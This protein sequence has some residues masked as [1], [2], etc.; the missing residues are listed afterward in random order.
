MK[1]I[2]ALIICVFSVFSL[3]AC[4]ETVELRCD[5]EGC[6]NT[7]T[8]KGEDDE[9]RVVFCKECSENELED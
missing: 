5:G 7:V 6:Q 4:E 1:R 3:T 2:I 8:V 9:D